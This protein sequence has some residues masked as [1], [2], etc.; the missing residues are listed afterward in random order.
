MNTKE[1][2]TKIDTLNPCL[3]GR[4]WIG[5]RQL[6]T[7]RELWDMCPRGDW[8]MWIATRMGVEPRILALG[9]IPVAESVL[10][11]SRDKYCGKTLELAKACLRGEVTTKEVRQ[12]AHDVHYGSFC[13]DYS[14]RGSF[15]VSCVRRT[16]AYAAYAAY[17]AVDG[18]SAVAPKYADNAVASV[19]II[20][21][22]LPRDE[23]NKLNS[24][25]AD[26]VRRTIK[27]EDVFG[28]E[29]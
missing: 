1:L 17:T 6:L 20:A 18:H 12:A 21:S 24:Q 7:P 25:C 5:K 26:I 19:A 9:A 2:I 29:R 3:V 16:V 22:Y 8:L 10:H 14:S 27:F 11:L 13:V 15:S 23:G 28:E 4:I